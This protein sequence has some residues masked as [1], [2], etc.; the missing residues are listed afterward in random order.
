MAEL[1]SNFGLH[2]FRKHGFMANWAWLLVVRLGHNLCC[3][4]QHPG[5]LG[6]GRDAGELRG[7]QLRYRYLVVPAVLVSCTVAGRLPS[8]SPS[9]TPTCSVSSARSNVSA[10]SARPSPDPT[11]ATA[12]LPQRSSRCAPRLGQGRALRPPSCRGGRPNRA[13][14]GVR[15]D[16]AVLSGVLSSS[17][18]RPSATLPSPTR[19]RNYAVS[20]GASE[21]QP[22]PRHAG[23]RPKW[24]RF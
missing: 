12:E 23:S 4:A 10:V 8:L 6:G 11:A 9:T 18:T 20:S 3:W 1:K 24:R 7:K 14:T 16:Q 15:T 17:S 22:A 19:W 2:A 5:R 13:K 21:Y